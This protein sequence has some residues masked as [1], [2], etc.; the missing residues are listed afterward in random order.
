MSENI[1]VTSD[2]IYIQHEHDNYFK[3]FVCIQLNVRN[4]YRG[5]FQMLGYGVT[6]L[7]S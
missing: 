4:N 7:T 5:D 1:C 2:M 3:A 6:V